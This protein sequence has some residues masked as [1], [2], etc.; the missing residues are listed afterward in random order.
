MG[1]TQNQNICRLETI[2]KG[3]VQINARYLLGHQM[4][5]PA[6]LHQRHQQGTGFFFCL[7]PSRF[8]GLAIGLAAD[9]GLRA[10][11]YNFAFL[12][13]RGGT[14]SPRLNHSNH[15]NAANL[16]DFIQCQRRGG[17]A[18]DYQQLR[19]AVFQKLAGLC[20]IPGNRFDGLGAVRQPRG[21]TEIQIIRGRDKF[22]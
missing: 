12:A 6:L 4:L 21:I 8:E 14:L 1:A 19:P 2:L 11:H 3:F 7:H 13:S 20:G 17:V 10:N 16:G 5:G 18:G 22:K 15:R 9:R